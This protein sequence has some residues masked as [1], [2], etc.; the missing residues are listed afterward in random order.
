VDARM[1]ADLADEIARMREVE[2]SQVRIEE[3]SKFRVKMQEYRNE[4]EQVHQEKLSRLKQREAETIERCKLKEKEIE[5]A[6]FD[7]RQ[8]VIKDMEILQIKE[9]EIKRGIDVSRKELQFEKQNVERLRIELEAKI[10][11]TEFI[12]K[13]CDRK[14]QEEIETYK[15][16]YD[17]E[18]ESLDQSLIKRKR[19][20]DEREYLLETR[21]AKCKEAE[22]ECMKIKGKNNELDEKINE[23]QTIIEE[24]ATKV[25]TSSEQLSLVT[26]TAKRDQEI[27]NSRETENKMLKEELQIM[28]KYRV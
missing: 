2:I 5:N 18:H 24:Q 20:I 1:R 15:L 11:D 7:H 12:K 13:D 10:K 8:K 27:L 23:L 17:R 6:S 4:L 28:K 21:E 16:R 9:Q 22:S 14:I 25:K 19:E 26:T 3:A